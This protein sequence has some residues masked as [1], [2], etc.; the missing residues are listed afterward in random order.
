M[1]S[2]IIPI[3]NE[4]ANIKKLIPY[5]QECIAGYDAE[6][7]ICDGGSTDNSVAIARFFNTK[8]ATSNQKGRALQMNSGACIAK[9][10]IFYFVH[11]DAIPPS[12][13]YSDIIAAQQS[14]FEFGRY[15]TKFDS[16]KW[17]LKLNAF[18]TRFDWYMC[19][20]SD[21]T[22]YITRSLFKNVNG[23][24]DNC[25]IMEEYDLV[26]K[27]KQ[28]SSYKI[29][30]KT[31]LVSDRKYDNNSWFKVQ[32]AN[33]KTVQLFKKGIPQA[34]LVAHYKKLLNGIR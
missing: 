33:Y 29:F 7:I 8:V 10:D 32:R 26:K 16:K 17:L 31:T 30:K 1:I 15:R 14:G 20:G 34:H 24:D 6:I 9:Y 21:Q 13:F 11:A 23:F 19:Y 27:A 28:F 22:L 25:L 5:L 4:E 2:I 18:F 12:T 3:F